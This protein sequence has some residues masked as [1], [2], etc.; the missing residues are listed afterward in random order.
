LAA[1]AFAAG[2]LAA[3]AFA[4]GAFAAGAFAA[5]AFAAGAFAAGAFA[6]G[7]FVAGAFAA[8]VLAT[9]VLATDALATGTSFDAGAAFDVSSLRLPI[10]KKAIP[11]LN[12]VDR[13]FIAS[14]G[15]MRTHVKSLS[16]GD[17]VL[18]YCA[19]CSARQRPHVQR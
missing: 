1:G 10:P 5:G 19:T 4:A 12:H 15:M 2:A 8:G 11:H 3:G 17:W 14:R 9:G 18:S 16:K 6:A 7:A 13:Y